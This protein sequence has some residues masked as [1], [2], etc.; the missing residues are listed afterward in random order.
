[1]VSRSLL[2][3]ILVA[4]L[5]CDTLFLAWRMEQDRPHAW[6]TYV[7]MDSLTVTVPYS[8]KGAALH[9]S[10]W[11][12]ALEEAEV[13]A[14]DMHLRRRPLWLIT[15]APDD[16]YRRFLAS[17]RD[18]KARQKCN[19]LILEGGQPVARPD[20]VPKNR[21]QELEVP[22]LVLCGRSIGDAGFSG[23]LPPDGTIRL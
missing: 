4:V 6:V 11:Q 23:A 13:A 19:V 5:G 7:G 3:V 22:A 9:A 8:K 20:S 2:I 15:L 16:S 12:P 14:N 18:L 1:M 17:I 21:Q 10:G